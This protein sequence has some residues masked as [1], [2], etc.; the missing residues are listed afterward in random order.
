M[1]GCGGLACALC[2]PDDD[3]DDDDDDDV[4][5][6]SHLGPGSM[7]AEGGVAGKARGLWV[8]A[9]RRQF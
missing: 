8:D 4:G 9:R 5:N 6:C 7:A 1:S 2:V 3:D